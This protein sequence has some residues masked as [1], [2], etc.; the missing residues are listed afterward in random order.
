MVFRVV[1]SGRGEGGVHGIAGGG[2]G[3]GLGAGAVVFEVFFAAA[4]ERRVGGCSVGGCQLRGVG[5]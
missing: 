2:E 4:G 3:V 5:E 1:G